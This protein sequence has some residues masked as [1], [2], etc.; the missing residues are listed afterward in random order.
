MDLFHYD[1]TRI[2]THRTPYY[3]YGNEPEPYLPPLYLKQSV[4]MAARMVAML[5]IAH[6]LLLTW[7]ERPFISGRFLCAIIGGMVL[8]SI[9]YVRREE[10][11]QEETDARAKRDY[12]ARLA[13]WEKKRDAEQKEINADWEKDFAEYQVRFRQELYEE[14]N[15]RRTGRALF[16]GA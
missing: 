8:E 7:I 4:V 1:Q 5:C 3:S 2:P 9:I 13:E 14:I 11:K 6:F 15:E 10:R 16:R 12:K